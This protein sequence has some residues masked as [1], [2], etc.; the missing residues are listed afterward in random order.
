MVMCR[1][2]STRHTMLA[3]AQIWALWHTLFRWSP[4]HFDCGSWRLDFT[5]VNVIP[6]EVTFSEVQVRALHTLYLGKAA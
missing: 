5:L 3:A 6:D 2:A 4:L 1:Y